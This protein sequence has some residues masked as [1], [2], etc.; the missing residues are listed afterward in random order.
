[1]SLILRVI[2]VLLPT[3]VAFRLR[4]RLSL[5]RSFHY[6]GTSTLCHRGRV[7]VTVDGDNNLRMMTIG[8]QQAPLIQSMVHCHGSVAESCFSADK[9]KPSQLLLRQNSSDDSCDLSPSHCPCVFDM[10]RLPP[11]YYEYESMA[12]H[13]MDIDSQGGGHV[14]LV[15][16]GGGMLPQFVL[17]NTLNVSVD[18]AEIN[19]D[20]VTAARAFF[21]VADAEQTGRMTVQVSDGLSA[22]SKVRPASYAA[23]V[24]DCCDGEHVPLPCRSPE[25]VNAVRKALQ[26][27]G[28]AIQNVPI[29]G[30]HN[31]DLD[32]A[33]AE[34]RRVFGA[35]AVHL[36][37]KGDNAVIF[38]TT[39]EA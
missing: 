19:E 5:R 33:L 12:D 13:L 14:F 16:L 2:A 17:S 26:P 29:G 34:Y 32:A 23:V 15:G 20:V 1:M 4:E 31:S 37:P 11:T 27:G 6:R 30:G 25:L 18:V 21:G 39:S 8:D 22:L 36:E 3:V 28:V 24:V 10:A 38:V 9:P 7:W 35:D